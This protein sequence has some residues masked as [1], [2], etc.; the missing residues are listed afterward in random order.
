L[1]HRRVTS[2]RAQD[3]RHRLASALHDAAAEAAVRRLSA[4]LR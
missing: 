3:W 1:A 4:L 2:A